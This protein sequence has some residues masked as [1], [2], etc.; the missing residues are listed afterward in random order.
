MHEAPRTVVI[1][2]GVAGLVA[3]LRLAHRGHQVTVLERADVP[4]GKIHTQSVGPVQ[5]E[6]GR[7]HV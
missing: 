7:A 4:G 1:G 6:I 2:A 3:A 5:I